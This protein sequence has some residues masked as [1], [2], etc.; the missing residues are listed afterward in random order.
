MMLKPQQLTH[1]LCL[2]LLLSFSPSLNGNWTWFFHQRAH[3]SAYTVNLWY[4]KNV[5]RAN[6]RLE[7]IRAKV[8]FDVKHS[9]FTPEVTRMCTQ[10]ACYRIC[11]NIEKNTEGRWKKCKYFSFW[12]S[13]FSD[14]QLYFVGIDIILTAVFTSSSWSERSEEKK[15][16]R[17]IRRKLI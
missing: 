7:Y 17:A 5:L 16:E 1:S 13:H 2:S 3:S 8:F 4:N 12:E 15:N 10:P 6:E 14:R 11:M 9:I